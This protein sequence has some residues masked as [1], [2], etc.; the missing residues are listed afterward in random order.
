M[1]N[2]VSIGKLCDVLGHACNRLFCVRLY[3]A[4]VDLGLLATVI[5]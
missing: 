2:A 1:S 3:L 5:R 4:G